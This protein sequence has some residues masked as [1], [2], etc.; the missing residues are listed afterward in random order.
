MFLCLD[1]VSSILD[2]CAVGLVGGIHEPLLPFIECESVISSCDSVI[3]DC[4]SV[5]TS[6]ESEI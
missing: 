3:S 4:N 1:Y 5:I 2:F 6:C